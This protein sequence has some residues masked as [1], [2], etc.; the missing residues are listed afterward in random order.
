MA[1][2]VVHP[3]TGERV[4]FHVTA[5][6]S[7]GQLLEM[8]DFW[9]AG[10]HATA[11]HVHPEMQERWEVVRG[12]VGFRIGERELAAGPGDVVVAP[13]GFAHRA[14]NRGGDAVHLRIQMTPAL[15]WEQVVRRL[16]AAAGPDVAPLLRE[17]PRELALPG[18]GQRRPGQRRPM[19]P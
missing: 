9:P 19:T 4:V 16:F 15:R 8:D 12:Q 18:S 6:Q 10:E 2:E 1:D 7:G 11:E 14:W 3:V 13:A 17:F 5:A